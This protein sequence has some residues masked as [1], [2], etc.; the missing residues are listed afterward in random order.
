MNISPAICSLDQPESSFGVIV[1]NIAFGH[2]LSRILHFVIL[3]KEG[4]TA[5]LAWGRTFAAESGRIF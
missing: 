4:T 1:F 2:G 3:D 5:I